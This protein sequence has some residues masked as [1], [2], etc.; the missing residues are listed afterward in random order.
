MSGKNIFV[1]THGG[2]GSRN[3]YS[4]GAL[5]AAEAGLNAIRSGS[6]VFDGV[7]R[8]VTVLEDDTRFNAGLGSHARADGSVQMDASVMDDEGRFGAVTCLEG[9]RNPVLIARGVS[10]TS[11][12]ILADRGAAQFAEAGGYEK[13]NLEEM[14]TG[15]ATDFSSEELTTD[16]VG[17]VA[18][19]GYQFAAGL[20][21][22]GINGAHPGRVGDVPLI[23]CGLFAG[24]QG[25][26]ASTGDGEAITINMTA[27]RAYQLIEQGKSAEEVLQQAI[28]W[29]QETE[30]FGLLVV[31]RH[32]YAGG[33][34]R[35]M[36]WAVRQW[37]E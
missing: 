35:T 15:D 3:E 11:Y 37:P 10:S 14:S 25:A 2:A 8:A 6:S 28:G 7:C 21:T 36:A 34:N 31:T 22:G 1:L 18:F 9:F 27:I 20:S 30:A 24:P 26:V 12:N 23:G 32:G 33:S 13:V 29:F 4:D 16:T 5:M 19:D 17:A